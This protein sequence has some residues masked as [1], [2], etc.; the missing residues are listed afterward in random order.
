MSQRT[1]ATNFLICGGR[2]EHLQKIL[3]HSIITE[4]MIYVHIVEQ[5]TDLHICNMDSIF[6]S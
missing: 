2:V 3:A 1:F 5:I 6:N 4:A